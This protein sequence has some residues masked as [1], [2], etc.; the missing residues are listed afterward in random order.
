MVITEKDFGSLEV[1]YIPKKLKNSYTIK[2]LQQMF[3][4]CNHMI[5]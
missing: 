4:E 2:I 5:K 1:E 3:I